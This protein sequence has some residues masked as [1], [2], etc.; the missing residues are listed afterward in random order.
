[1]FLHSMFDR[2][3]TKSKKK[4]YYNLS[5]QNCF[6]LFTSME[7]CSKLHRHVDV[8][9]IFFTEFRFIPNGFR[10]DC[11]IE[12]TKLRFSSLL[13]PF[14]VEIAKCA[15]LQF[16]FCMFSLRSKEPEPKALW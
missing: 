16:F 10:I 5:S 12:I 7:N 4:M 13:E 1:M 15:R 9:A 14:S 6:F 11:R 2:A 3:K 8:V